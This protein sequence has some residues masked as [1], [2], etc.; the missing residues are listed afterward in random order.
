MT[1]S[2]R[3]SIRNMVLLAL[4]TQHISGR[5]LAKQLNIS[6]DAIKRILAFKDHELSDRKWREVE[7][8]LKRK[9]SPK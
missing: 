2:K 8:A 4:V 7:I 9:Y 6:S 5:A 1:R 3:E